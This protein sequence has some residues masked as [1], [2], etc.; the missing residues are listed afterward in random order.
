[1]KQEYLDIVKEEHKKW[2]GR[3]LD[4]RDRMCAIAA[5]CEAIANKRELTDAEINLAHKV[6]FGYR[7]CDDDLKFARAVIAAHIA[8]QS[9]PEE[10]P[11]SQERFDEGVWMVK[12]HYKN[13]NA[14]M[15]KPTFAG[16]DITKVTLLRK[17]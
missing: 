7:A 17:P 3:Y 9:E 5:R 13:G 2:S 4:V 1:M 10:I 14:T 16:D 12:V 11:F 15:T 6:T 8:K